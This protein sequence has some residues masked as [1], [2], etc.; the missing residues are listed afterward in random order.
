MTIHTDNDLIHKIADIP[1]DVIQYIPLVKAHVKVWVISELKKSIDFGEIEQDK[2]MDDSNY[3]LLVQMLHMLICRAWGELKIDISDA[4]LAVNYQLA[5][6]LYVYLYNDF[7]LLS[8]NYRINKFDIY[9]NPQFKKKILMNTIEVLK[10]KAK[11]LEGN[12][13]IKEK[14]EDALLD[15]ECKVDY[16]GDSKQLTALITAMRNAKIYKLL[17]VGEKREKLI[18]PEILDLFKDYFYIMFAFQSDKERMKRLTK[19][20]KNNPKTK[21]EPEEYDLLTQLNIVHRGQEASY[22]R[23]AYEKEYMFE[24][25]ELRIVMRQIFNGTVNNSRDFAESTFD[26]LS[27]YPLPFY[28]Y[29]LFY[30]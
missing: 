7:K 29:T 27:G 16:H 21:L 13:E 19:N 23:E 6:D 22:V 10:E 15:L 24:F 12:E 14:Y 30:G 5:I 4:M 28:K 26:E 20:L 17:N 8:I 11:Y 2:L 25:N 3:D 18:Y 1:D 9:F